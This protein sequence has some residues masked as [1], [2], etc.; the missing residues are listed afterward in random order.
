MTATVK[1]CHAYR[2]N[3]GKILV[4]R[5]TLTARRRSCLTAKSGSTFFVLQYDCIVISM[6][7]ALRNLASHAIGTSIEYVYFRCRLT[8]VLPSRQNIDV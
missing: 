1:L 2:S 7:Y 3:S 6:S 4:D 5:A 8:I